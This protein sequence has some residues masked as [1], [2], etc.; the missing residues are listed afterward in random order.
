VLLV[1]DDLHAADHGTLTVL[2]HL[3][4]APFAE[5]VAFVIA[6]REPDASDHP[7]AAAVA[8]LRRECDVTRVR[9]DGLAE[10][11]VAA[12][13]AETAGDSVAAH[14]SSIRDRTG[15]NPFFV[16]ELARNAV[17]A[18]ADEIELDAVP[19]GVAEVVAVRAARLGAAGTEV[20]SGASVL[21]V[22]FE[23]RVLEEVVAVPPARLLNELERAAGARLVE[24]AGAGRYRFAHALI[25]EALYERLEPEPPRTP[26]RAG[27]RGAGAAVSGGWAGAGR[28]RVPPLRRG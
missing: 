17:E 27:G 24:E 20:L 2:S 23:L 16:R 19:E 14:A 6:Y 5:R 22:E 4:R 11:D 7:L 15:G 18:G 3:V 9:L 13:V 12:L 21:G 25:R 28:D 26:P 1:L 8:D 10:Q